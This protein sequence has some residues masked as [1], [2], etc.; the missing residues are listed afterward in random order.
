MSTGPRASHSTTV[1]FEGSGA[2]VD[3]ATV[4]AA[5][6][7]YRL[8]WLNH[9]LSLETV[10]GLPF[11]VKF[12]AT[13]TLATDSIAPT[14][15]GI[16]T[17]VGPLGS[18]LG[19]ATAAPIMVSL[20]YRFLDHGYIRPYAGGG[21]GVLVALD[22]K[23]TNPTLTMVSQPDMSIAPA[24]GLLLQGG[25]DIKLYQRWY[26]R[27]DLKFIAFMTSNAEVHHIQVETPNIPLFGTVEV[28]TAKMS[29]TVNPL[30]FGAGV[31]CDF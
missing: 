3:S 1:R 7:G 13:G 19:E 31:G 17:G 18:E 9:K 4:F 23:A 21:F 11:K 29:V 12:K 5:I 24:P 22:A 14:A 2:S 25:V 16:P 27:L 8:P 30:V 28:G 26:A 10:L 15:L 20:L 6:V